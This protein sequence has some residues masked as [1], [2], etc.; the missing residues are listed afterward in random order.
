LRCKCFKIIITTNLG[1]I[2]TSSYSYSL[3]LAKIL[4]VYSQQI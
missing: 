1:S 3:I 2:F 4:H